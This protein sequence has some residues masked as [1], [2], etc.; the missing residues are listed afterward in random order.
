MAAIKTLKSWPEA[1][2]NALSVAYSELDD[3]Y[4]GHVL[5]EIEGGLECAVFPTVGEAE[6]AAGF[7]IN[8][9]LCGYYSV[10]L[11]PGSGRAVTHQS[12]EEWLFG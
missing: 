7:A 12:A 5:M 10:V 11:R 8:L 9:S 3:V 1:G 2:R 4:D 6:K